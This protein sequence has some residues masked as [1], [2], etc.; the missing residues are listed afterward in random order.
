MEIRLHANATTTIT[1]V[2]YTHLDVY[3]RQG[4]ATAFRIEPA[5]LCSPA[6]A[7]KVEAIQAIG[8]QRHIPTARRV[9]AHRGEDV[10]SGLEPVLGGDAPPAQ[11]QLA[12][13]VEVD[14]GQQVDAGAQAAVLGDTLLDRCV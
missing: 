11:A 13:Q 1:T 2:S 9:L 10:Q 7:R 3:K 8:L 6:T 12:Q 5:D 4:V 14:A